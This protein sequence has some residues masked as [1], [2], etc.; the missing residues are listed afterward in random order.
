MVAAVRV[1][2]AVL[3]LAFVA[4]VRA[5]CV[6][7]SGFDLTKLRNNGQDYKIPLVGAN[8]AFNFC[9]PLVA[10]ASATSCGDP[11]NSCVTGT[12]GVLVSTAYSNWNNQAIFEVNGEIYYKVSLTN[13]ARSMTV[14]LQCGQGTNTATKSDTEVDV[15]FYSNLVPCPAPPSKDKKKLSTGSILTIVFF[16]TLTVYFLLGAVY[17]HYRNN[18]SGVEMVPNLEFWQSLP[19]LIKEGFMFS[20]HCICRRDGTYTPVK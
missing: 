5:A 18:R 19:G 12:S 8:L 7:P 9:G 2:V 3:A 17:N 15:V 16:V 4:S 20:T 6:A 14:K 13:P 11:I 1:A 10:P